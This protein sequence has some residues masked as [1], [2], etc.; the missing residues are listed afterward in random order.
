M[1]DI[2]H[3]LFPDCT[4]NAKALVCASLPVNEERYQILRSLH[5]FLEDR[6]IG[7]VILMDEFGTEIDM[8]ANVACP[9]SLTNGRYSIQK[10]AAFPIYFTQ[11][12]LTE[13][14]ETITEVS[15]QYFLFFFKKGFVT[16]WAI[17]YGQEEI[18][19]VAGANSSTATEDIPKFVKSL[20]VGANQYLPFSSMFWQENDRTKAPE[21]WKKI[22]AAKL[23]CGLGKELRFE[24][25]V[26]EITF[27]GERRVTL[28]VSV[29]SDQLVSAYPAVQAIAQWLYQDERGADT[30][31]TLI[32]NQVALLSIADVELIETNLKPVAEKIMAAAEMAYRYYLRNSD[33][34]LNKSLTELNKTLFEHT[35]K[36]RQN[37]MDLISGLWRDFTTAF[38]LL[39]LNFSLKKPEVSGTYWNWLL[40]GLIA[41]LIIN[42]TL[43]GNLGFWFYY[44]LKSSIT[45][46]RDRVYSYLTNE[47]F[48]R[49][50]LDPLK[51]AFRKYRKTFWLI[52][53]CYFA[54]I[55]LVFVAIFRKELASANPVLTEHKGQTKINPLKQR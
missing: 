24:G 17:F 3:V 1:I 44:R 13:H 48:N 21:W 14:L 16:K 46:M 30:R 31:H 4:E 8:N 45:D 47:D 32:N 25:H 28:N 38:G 50:A 39:V 18:D 20:N 35:S 52:S 37:T 11:R 49:Y 40:Y 55:V 43:T 41:Y 53:A 54:I 2:Q 15:K 6:N 33:K 51:T 36:I 22:S 34:E 9:A 26:A 5:K 7:A 42:L 27:L 19:S 12:A 23:F 29:H 10:N